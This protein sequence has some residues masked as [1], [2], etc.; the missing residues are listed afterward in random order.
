MLQYV[1][2]VK[3][4]FLSQK[5]KLHLIPRDMTSIS[6]LWICIYMDV[7]CYKMHVL[8]HLQL[9]FVGLHAQDKSWKP[10]DHWPCDPENPEVTAR[11]RWWL[12]SKA[13]DNYHDEK[14]CLSVSTHSSL[15][16]EPPHQWV[17]LKRS[18]DMRQWRISNMTLSHYKTWQR[19]ALLLRSCLN[20]D[21]MDNC[22]LFGG[23]FTANL[24][25]MGFLGK[26][27]M[28]I[29]LAWYKECGERNYCNL[30]VNIL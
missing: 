17:L 4:I 28:C 29:L 26:Q 7:L 25:A 12:C 24:P 19:R 23:N 8:K 9:W 15:T 16:R 30:T 3:C 22:T 21:F 13:G 6:F 10:A 14:H 18:R 27:K 2:V 11:A 1:F 5:S 20:T